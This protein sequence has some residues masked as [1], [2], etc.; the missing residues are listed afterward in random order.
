MRDVEGLWDKMVRFLM[1]SEWYQS[2]LEIDSIMISVK[3]WFTWTYEDEAEAMREVDG[4]WDLVVSFMRKMEWYQSELEI[5][6]IRS[7]IKSWFTWTYEDEAEAIWRWCKCHMREV[8]GRWDIIEK[9]LRKRELYQ[10]GLEIDSLR[11][12]I[13]SWFTGTYEDEAEAI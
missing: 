2:G 4:R 10:S 12:S 8:E 11:I 13:K 9:F 1:K 3:S 6:S 5:D 7:S